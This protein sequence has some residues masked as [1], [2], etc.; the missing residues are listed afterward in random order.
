MRPEERFSKI[1]FGMMMIGSVFFRHGKWFIL[2]LGF[3]FIISA[4]WGICWDCK[5]RKLFGQKTKV[6]IITRRKQ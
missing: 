6:K 1:C 4:A 5:F 3:L 2:A